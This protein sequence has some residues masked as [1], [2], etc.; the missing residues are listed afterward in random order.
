LFSAVAFASAFGWYRC[1]DENVSL[2]VDP[3]DFASA[4]DDMGRGLSG[5]RHGLGGSRHGKG[6]SLGFRAKT[7]MGGMETITSAGAGI[8]GKQAR[9]DGDKSK[10]AVLLTPSILFDNSPTRYARKECTF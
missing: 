7:G 5:S 4:N 8:G 10:W 1:W 6:R 3:S 2:L 9:V